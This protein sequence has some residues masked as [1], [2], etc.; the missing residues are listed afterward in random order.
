[1]K[2]LYTIL[3]LMLSFSQAHA[4]LH[5]ITVSDNQFTP[6]TL[7]AECGDTVKWVWESGDHTTWSTSIPAGADSWVEY[8]N[9]ID[10]TYSY[11]VNEA[12]TYNYTCYFHAMMT[13][14][15]VVTCPNGL[16]SQSDNFSSLVYPN[17]FE[18]NLTIETPDATLISIYTITG[19]KTK[20]II[21]TEGQTKTQIN[22]RDMAPGIYLCAILKKGVL[23]D[24]RK[25]LKQ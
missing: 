8:I 19:E 4:A 13:G 12:G 3:A 23:I 10:T 18:D 24:R 11:Q 15:I 1:M 7:N 16:A 17:P 21:L 2:K 22:T 6:A 25:L 9:P 20:T 14:S 5:I